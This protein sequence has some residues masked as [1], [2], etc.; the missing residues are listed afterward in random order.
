M[1]AKENSSVTRRQF[2]ETTTAV[3]L[4]TLAENRT[5]AASEP[6]AGM[7]YRRLG[8]TNL[9]ISEIGLGCASGLRSQQLGPEMFNKYREELPAMTHK[10]LEH[11]G[12]FVA[13]SASYHDTEEILGRAL[14]GRRK[15]A[16]IFTASGKRDAKAVIA[17]CE[18]SLTRFQTDVIDGYFGHGGWSDGFAEAAQKLK[19]QGK[20]RFIGMSCHIPEQHRLRVETGLVD[21]ILQPYNYMNLAK[22]T[23]KTDRVGTEELFEL[24]KKKDVG[25]MVIKPMT[26]HFIPNWAKKTD[27]PK[28]AGLLKELKAL[29]KQN[30]YQAFLMWVLKNPSVSCAIVGMGATQDV[31][32]NC[33]AV[34]RKF[35]ALHERLL[36]RYA[37]LATGDYCR[38][39]ETCVSVCPA[40]VRIPDI[41]RYRMYHQN[42]G[43]RRDARELYASLASHQQAPACTDCRQC[44][45]VC[46]ARLA[47]VRKL[48]AAH[49]LLA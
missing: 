9:R 8:R 22:W 17:D 44:E 28:V 7:K 37:S 40:G 30:L 13:T 38:M 45:Q 10:L 12:N 16:F 1:S 18:R 2:L 11:G 31:T 34:T 39:C 33:A 29:G 26:G 25:V 48:K 5:V 42:Y 4:G 46:P 19:Q 3:A 20:I 24:C 6:A 23:E 47:I 49:E 15:D 27:D 32:E 35:G 36:D 41:L 43:H 14:K 21:F